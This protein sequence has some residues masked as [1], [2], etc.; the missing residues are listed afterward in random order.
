MSIPQEGTLPQGST[1]VVTI[2]KLTFGGSGMA[3]ID[4]KTVFVPGTLPGQKVEIT[5][6][7]NKENYCEARLDK[8]QRKAKEEI[9]PR[10]KHF[11][12]CGGCV[13]QNLPYDKQISYK[14]EIV[15]ETLEHLTPLDAAE[16]KKLPGRVL[17]IIPSP[18]VFHYRNKLE[19][20]FGFQSMRTEQVNGKRVYLD[21]NPSIGF[22]KPGQWSTVLPVE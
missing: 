8:V 19:L 12:D 15:R 7:K 18:Q 20:S 4:G 2:E 13:W 17:K 6:L 10:C 3:R 16:R 5:I 9:Q 11:I 1:H 21:E 22:H 14:E